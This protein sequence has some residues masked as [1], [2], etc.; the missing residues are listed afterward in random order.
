M[1]ERIE[2]V[3]KHKE[4]ELVPSEP[5]KV[6]RIRSRFSLQMETLTIEFL[7]KNTNLFAWSP[8]DFKGLDPEVIVHRLNV[9][10]QAKLVK[11]K[12]RSFRMDRNRIIEEVVNKL[13]KA[14]YVA[15]V[16]YTD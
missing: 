4:I 6:T 2:P 5:K 14:G 13:L 7:R 11:Q 10:P 8:S 3:E 9:D 12:K 15:E 1:M 16:R